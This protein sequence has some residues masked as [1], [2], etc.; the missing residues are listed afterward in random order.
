MERTLAGVAALSLLRED[1]PQSQDVLQKISTKLD[2]DDSVS[3]AA[4][5]RAAQD[6]RRTASELRPQEFSLSRIDIAMQ[7]ADH[8]EMT[9]MLQDIAELLSPA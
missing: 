3:L 5:S 1:N 2:A 4:R 6:L 7:R 8:T 9:Q